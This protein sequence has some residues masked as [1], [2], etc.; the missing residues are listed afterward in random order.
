MKI[1]L[2]VIAVHPDDA[3]LS[4]SG[5]LL[6]HKALGKKTGVIDLT[7]GELGT[8]GN[9]TTRAAEA[10]DAAR[11]L[12]LDV[13]ENLG[14]RDGFFK[15]DEEHQLMIIRKIRQYE[16][17]I[18][19]TNAL[20]DRH[21]DHG[22]AAGLV[23][24]AAFLSGL[25]K[26][27]TELDGK[28]QNAWRPRLLLNFIQN[29]YIKPDIIIDI[30][31]FWEEKMASIA[32]YK[33]QFYNPDANEEHETYISSPEFVKV[34]EAKA[35]ELGISINTNYAEGF[36]CSKLLGVDNLFELK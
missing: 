18:I 27:K 11:I 21:P 25:V 33:T 24:D 13:R 26:I 31:P 8:R 28:Q 20:T 34:I 35:R 22:R 14:M 5:T 15:N 7:R 2:L 6:K 12:K 3:E 10:A 30:T 4:C 29:A 1:D 9:E 23:N 36:T 17:E 19:I 16:P 32:A